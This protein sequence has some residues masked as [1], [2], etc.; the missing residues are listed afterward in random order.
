MYPVLNCASFILE[1]PNVHVHFSMSLIS[2]LLGLFFLSQLFLFRAPCHIL[3]VR[4]F[5]FILA[6]FC[7]RDNCM[8]IKY[9]YST[10][11]WVLFVFYGS[12]HFHPCLHFYDQASESGSCLLLLCS[13]S[14]MSF[15]IFNRAMAV[16]MRA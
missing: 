15:P 11:V 14:A 1:S 6:P 16:F 12:W 3:Y 7:L 2:C 4:T 5:Y 10:F 8:C 9:I 13:E